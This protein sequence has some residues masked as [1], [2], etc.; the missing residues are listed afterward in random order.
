MAKSESKELKVTSIE[1]LKNLSHGEIVEL[2][3]FQG[4]VPFVARLKRPSMLSLVK[5]GQIP[6][7]LLK[8]ANSLFSGGVGGVVKEGAN[9]DKMMSNLLSILD[10]ICEASFVEPT[11]QQ[12]RE[13]GVELTDEQYMAVFSYT[14]KGVKS[15]ENFRIKR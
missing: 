15:L 5:S 9:D 3:P 11:Y 13:A 14:Q 6:N 1:E 4:D 10:A 12:L 8:E 7:S 2:P